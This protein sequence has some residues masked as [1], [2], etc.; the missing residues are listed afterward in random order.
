MDIFKKL[1][2][3]FTVVTICFTGYFFIDG[4]YA[5]S[6]D[7]QVVEYR[8]DYLELKNRYNWV[9]ERVWKLEDRYGGEGVPNASQTVKEE[10]RALIVELGLLKRNLEKLGGR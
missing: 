6:S 7:M 2:P 10:Y 9:Q 1:V 8:V 4:N 5:R 3:V